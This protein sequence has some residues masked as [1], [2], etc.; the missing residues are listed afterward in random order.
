MRTIAGLLLATLL[1]VSAGCAKTEGGTAPMRAVKPGIVRIVGTAC[2]IHE[3][4]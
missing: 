4:R 3:L 2:G 1:A